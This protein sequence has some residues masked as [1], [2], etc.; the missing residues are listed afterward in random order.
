MILPWRDL[1]VGHMLFAPSLD[2]AANHYGN[3]PLLAICGLACAMWEQQEPQPPLSAPAAP[4][5]RKQSFETSQPLPKYDRQ[6]M[7][8][9]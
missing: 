6:K 1:D 2:R 7:V 9:W 5:R 4:T 8:L 3:S